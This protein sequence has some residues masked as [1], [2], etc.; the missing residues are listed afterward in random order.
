MAGVLPGKC[1][2][3]GHLVRFGYIELEENS[4]YFMPR[5]SRIRAH[6]FHYYDSEDN[7]AD[8][9]ATKPP[10]H[11]RHWTKLSLY[12]RGRESLVRF[13]PPLLSILPGV[14]GAL[15]GECKK[16]LKKRKRYVIIVVSFLLGG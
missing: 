14:R 8:C 4:G 6:E 15:R 16:I 12:P 11:P 13:S 9:I 5:G 10:P 2:D 7:G 3:T 1:F